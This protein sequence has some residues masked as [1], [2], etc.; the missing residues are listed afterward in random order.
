MDNN[1][2]EKNQEQEKSFITEKIKPKTKRKIK[3]VLE[4]CGFALLAA[5]II[6]FVSRIVFVLSEE[7]VKKMLGVEEKQPETMLVN[8]T[9]SEVKLST[10]ITENGK[11]SPTVSETPVPSLE[12]ENTPAVSPSPTL[13]R[14]VPR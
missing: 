5:V 1:N 6:G 3:K 11:I 7:P 12:A 2:I 14:T 9:R 8:P 4:V 13:T 10:G